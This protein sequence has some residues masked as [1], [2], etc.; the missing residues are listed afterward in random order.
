[1][2][3]LFYRGLTLVVTFLE[4]KQDKCVICGS[5]IKAKGKYKYCSERCARRGYSKLGK[6]AR[7]RK[8]MVTD[9]GISD[10]EIDVLL[11]RFSSKLGAALMA[12]KTV[13][14][15]LTEVKESRKLLR[16]CHNVPRNEA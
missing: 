9:T 12:L 11:E 4:P 14:A 10:E 15:L 8:K 16:E 5:I 2:L 6:V 7:D 3:L 13:H 1:M